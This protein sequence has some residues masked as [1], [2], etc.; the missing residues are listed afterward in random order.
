MVVA[1]P[2]LVDWSRRLFHGGA[3]EFRKGIHYTH[4]PSPHYTLL[5]YH[6]LSQ[7]FYT[8]ISSISSVY[9]PKIIGC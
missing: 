1:W 2:R 3:A 9:I 4:N 7:L 8:F 5:S 6:R